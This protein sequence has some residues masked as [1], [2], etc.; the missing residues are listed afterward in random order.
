MSFLGRRAVSGRGFISIILSNASPPTISYV[1]RRG[2]SSSAVWCNEVHRNL[3]AYRSISSGSEE[4]NWNTM[5]GFVVCQILGGCELYAMS[6]RDKKH[7]YVWW[8]Y[9]IRERVPS[10]DDSI[11]DIFRHQPD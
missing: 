7:R 6:R 2:S 9:T 5:A 10:L 8:Y 1:W 3:N 4:K 11:D